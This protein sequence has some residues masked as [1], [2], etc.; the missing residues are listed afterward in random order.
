MRDGPPRTILAFDFGLK[1]IGIASGDTITSTAAPRPAVSVFQS[2]PDWAAIEREVKAL[3][4][5]ILVV[6]VPY[7]ADGSP[8]ALTASA[9]EFAA[10]LE[11]RFGIPVKHVDERWSSLEASEA[12]KRGRASG[13]R[14]RR[15]QREDID[16]AAA[17]IIL[18]RWFSGEDLSKE[19][20]N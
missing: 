10:A 9:R 19:D 4:P 14:R 15:V 20:K 12:L 3:Q 18:E 5:Q 6:G 7:N 16:S 8:G 17:A 1:R 11:H 13:E 2:G